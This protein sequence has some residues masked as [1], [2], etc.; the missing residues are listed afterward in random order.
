MTPAQVRDLIERARRSPDDF[1][2]SVARLDSFLRGVIVG[3]SDLDADDGGERWH[4]HVRC[5]STVDALCDGAL[6][7]CD[8]LWPEVTP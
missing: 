2:E 1:E 7:V 8:G 3:A 5:P 4:R 6:R